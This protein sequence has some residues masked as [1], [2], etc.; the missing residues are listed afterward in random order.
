MSSPVKVEEKFTMKGVEHRVLRITNGRVLLEN[1]ATTET[2]EV[3]VDEVLEHYRH[4]DLIVRDSTEQ[5]PVQFGQTRPIATLD[6]ERLGEKGREATVKRGKWLTALDRIDAFGSRT[7]LAQAVDSLAAEFNALKAPSLSSL[8]RWRRNWVESRK[9]PRSLMA[10]FDRRGGRHKYR[11]EPEVEALIAKHADEIFLGQ[12]R[13]TAGEVQRAVALDVSEQNKHRVPSQHLKEPSLRTIQSRMARLYAFDVSI[14]RRGARAAKAKY[15][16]SVAARPTER[17]LEVVE[18]DHTP[19]DL[20]VVDEQGRFAGKPTMTLLLDRH[21]RCVCGFSLSLTGHGVDAVFSALRHAILPKSYLKKRYPE[22]QGTWPC[23]GRLT[24]L[25][26]DNGSELVG[27]SLE[28]AAFDLRINLEFCGSMTPNDKPH[29]ERFFYTFNYR[30]IH[31]LKG[32]SLARVSA[33]EGEQLQ[34]D[35]CLTLSE[36][37]R[38]IH[39]WIVDVYHSRPH[40]GLDGRT[41]ADV[42]AESAQRFPPRLELNVAQIDGA[43]SEV[44]TRSLGRGGIEIN[45]SRYTSERLCVLRRMM[46]VGS[47]V[48]VKYRRDDVGSI[49]VL[50]EFSQEYF[51]V[52]NVKPERSGLSIE[53]DKEVRKQR[54]AGGTHNP[55]RVASAEAIIRNRVNELHAKRKVKDR[56]KASRLSGMNSSQARQP[57]KAQAPK[58][59]KAETAVGLFD[60]APVKLAASTRRTTK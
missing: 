40:E 9:D 39:V 49:L 48:K 51:R 56:Q 60:G 30:F 42:W 59:T 38:L 36:L 43:L 6:M 22:V 52:P 14:A 5:Q 11:M 1:T 23:Y 35:A 25:L 44:D 3:D 32:T 7:K 31:T 28:S 57:P 12:R 15:G 34:G 41:P 50:D 46:P 24:T 2:R 54:R 29:I 55:L 27:K 16:D 8:Y 17:I 13:A 26:A 45:N 37:E 33:R 47:K 4:G 21:S 53:Q 20:W 58:A 18:I 19:V 10:R